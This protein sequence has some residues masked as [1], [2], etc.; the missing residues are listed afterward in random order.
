[1]P[2]LSNIDK[3]RLKELKLPHQVEVIATRVWEDDEYGLK[4]SD[5]RYSM[6]PM[7]YVVFFAAFSGMFLWGTLSS[8]SSAPI[9]ARISAW[10]FATIHLTAAGSLFLT[11]SVRDGFDDEYCEVGKVRKLLFSY[12]ALRCWKYPNASVPAVANGLL[13]LAFLLVG[14]IVTAA[15]IALA[16][17]FFV[18]MVVKLRKRV[19][20][21]IDE[22][23]RA[24]VVLRHEQ[25]ENFSG[26][27]YEGRYSE[28]S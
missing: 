9:V 18:A 22:T 6:H 14:A 4:S 8:E 26:N 23:C 13:A 25:S 11:C 1:M 28:I 5:L 27:V 7:L 16:T 17:W 15:A 3:K 12:G 24:S 19:Q 10:L 2:A 21:C 20:E